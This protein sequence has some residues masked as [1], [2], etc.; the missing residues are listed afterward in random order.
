MI[1]Q[2][3]EDNFHTDLFH[4]IVE[5][6]LDMVPE[7]IPITFE[8]RMG[9]NMV[10]DHARAL[11]F[12]IA[13]GIYP[14][15]EG[16][17]YLLRRLLRRAL[18]RFY[19]YGIIEPFL[20]RLVDVVVATMKED[21]PELVDR[22]A[23]VAAIVRGEEESFFRTLADGKAR[24]ISI[25]RDAKES[26]ASVLDGEKAFLLHDTYGFPLDLTKT[27]AAAEGLAVDEKGFE[28]AMAEQRQRAQEGSSFAGE[29]TEHRFDERDQRRG[30]APNS[31]DTRASA[32][33]RSSGAG[34][35]SSA[36]RGRISNGATPRG[37]PSSSSSTRRR[38]TRHPAGRSPTRD[39]SSS[40][41]IGSRSGTSSSA[42]AR[43]CISS[44]P[45]GARRTRDT[46]F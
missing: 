36:L 25:A 20:H 35:R 13:E 32:A 2:G 30:R 26:G 3:V 16:R 43:S 14:S 37:S 15:N 46:S 28:A 4:P 22:S 17:G 11:T 31:P 42:G 24:F 10:A 18:T 39:I 45:P 5:E 38:S 40:P 29:G 9:I 7:G 1:L 6:L 19:S 23:D 27:L 21:Y 41:A 34:G 8:D 33:R 44:N 12:T